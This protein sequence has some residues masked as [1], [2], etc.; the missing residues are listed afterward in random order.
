MAIVHIDVPNGAGLVTV[1]QD[2]AYVSWSALTPVSQGRSDFDNKIKTLGYN[3]CTHEGVYTYDF[4][5][6]ELIWDQRGGDAGQTSANIQIYITL[7][8]KSD[9]YTLYYTHA[10]VGTNRPV[11]EQYW[12]FAID[13]ETQKGYLVGAAISQWGWSNQYEKNVSPIDLGNDFF[14]L[15]YENGGGAGS[16]YIGNSLLSNKKMV[17]YNVPTSS[18][19]GTKTESVNEVSASPVSGKPKSGN[20]FARIKFVRDLDISN[21][22]EWIQDGAFGWQV[23]YDSETKENHITGQCNQFWE[24]YEFPLDVERNKNY[25]VSLQ[26]KGTNYNYFALYDTLRVLDRW[27]DAT[28]IQQQD[29]INYNYVIA[30][31]NTHFSNQSSYVDCSVTFNSGDRDKVWL[32]IGAGYVYTSTWMDLYFK[33]ITVVKND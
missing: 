6:F 33:N 23:T 3:F 5:T 9:D 16:G 21:M 14:K 13:T 31:S 25:T 20:G 12:D 24:Y 2:D 8:R 7:K 18:A 27:Q 17:G 15:L 32:Y 26:F 4:G 1:L 10:D 29:G 28:Q 11:L 19:E 30:E 22:T